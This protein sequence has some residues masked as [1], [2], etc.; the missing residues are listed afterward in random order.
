[1]SLLSSQLS[2]RSLDKF[3]P[4]LNDELMDALTSV[5]DSSRAGGVDAREMMAAASARWEARRGAGGR[6]R[7]DPMNTRAGR[8]PTTAS[9]EEEDGEPEAAAT[10]PS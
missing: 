7:R 4:A 10:V 5:V 2:G 8:L 9:E 1:M 6:T 3:S